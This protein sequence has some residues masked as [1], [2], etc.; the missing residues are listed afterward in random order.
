MVGTEAVIKKLNKEIM[1]LKN[2]TQGG[3]TEAALLI[4]G[5]SQKMTPVVT[6]NLRNSSFITWPGG[7]ST[8]YGNFKG[9]ES[10]EMGRQHAAAVAESQAATSLKGIPIAEVG[11][12]A[13]YATSVHENP[14]AGQTGGT[15][16]S[17]TRK[18]TSGRTQSGRQST[19]IV[20]STV[21]GYKFLENAL[22]NNARRIF[23]IIQGS[24]RIR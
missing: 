23:K 5:E 8:T 22:K 18:Y 12:S 14:R 17:G 24:A 1:K 9:P 6:G 16:K 3:V 10:S 13:I 7:I 21:G 20:Y 15:N 2:R 4:K 11:Y 19:R